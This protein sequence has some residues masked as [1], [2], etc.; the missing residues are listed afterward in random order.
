M[1]LEL[2]MKN[3]ILLSGF[4]LT[5]LIYSC[6][7]EVPNS[8]NN[9]NY[10]SG[11]LF[12]KIDKENAPESVVWVEALLSRQGYDTVSGAMNL[13][14][15]STADL[16]LEN[17][18]AGDWHL[19]VN[20]KDSVGI[21]LYSGETDVL[22]L[23]GFTTQVNLVLEPTGA[24]VG[25]IYIWVTW[26][27]PSFSWQ[28][29]S[30][31]PIFASSGSYWDNNGVQQPKIL[32]ENNMM[33]MYYSGQGGPYTA[34]TGCAFSNDG[35]NWTTSPEN[36]VLSPGP[37]G[38]WDETAVAGATVMKDENGYKLYY[39]GW[40]DPFSN[41]HIGLATSSDGINWLKHPAPVLYATASGSEFQLAPS[42]IIRVDGIYYLY[43]TGRNLPHVD[44]R[45]A[46]SPD[47]IN[48]TRHPGNPI[49]TFSQ[50]WEGAG[51]YY[52]AVYKNNTQYLMIYMNVLGTGFGRATS[53]DGVNWTKDNSNPFFT[54]FDTHNNWADYKIAYPYYIK[55]NNQDR[56]YYTGLSTNG[57][58]F[59]MIGI[60]SK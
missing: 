18:Q 33:R 52:P 25:N 49:L 39:S 8:P 19:Q 37:I 48:W 5:L 10:Q 28:D 21:I 35:I 30:G 55:I 36:P 42:S 34:Y 13:L 54:K 4:L 59:G 38:S 45:L 23:A 47:G 12:L 15:D 22:I 29:Y 1:A 14:S 6:I 40:S 43:Y 32:I 50:S 44:I 24:G 20:A 58:P 56:I 41:W 16:L 53:T 57:D 2:I 51:V 60:I 17:I 11:K 3:L 27:V 26:G 7:Q 46:T 31:N 9:E